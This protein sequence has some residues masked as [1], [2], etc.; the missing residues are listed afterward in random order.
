MPSSMALLVCLLLSAA[1]YFAFRCKT[2]L[3]VCL[4]LHKTKTPLRDFRVPAYEK[5]ILPK[6]T[7]DAC[8]QQLDRLMLEELLFLDSSLSLVSLAARLEIPHH[9]LTQVL[10]VGMGTSFYRYLA[11][12]RVDYVCKLIGEFGM[13]IKL[14]V[15]SARSGFNSKTSFN[16]YFKEFRGVT[17]SQYRE[18]LQL[19]R[20]ADSLT[21]VNATEKHLH[22]SY[23]FC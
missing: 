5:C 2:L 10:N 1:L 20:T 8:Q 13:N 12:F 15:L 9:H 18:Q 19:A 23:D 22:H 7:L 16:R 3:L 6:A 4:G 14:E 17:P 11:K 21:V